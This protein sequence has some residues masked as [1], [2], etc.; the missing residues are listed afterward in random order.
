M[1]ADMRDFFDSMVPE[2]IAALVFS[3]ACVYGAT[4]FIGYMA[5]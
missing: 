4:L 3:Q 1:E 2:V 5:E